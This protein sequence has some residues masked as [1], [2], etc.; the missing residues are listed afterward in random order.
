M[1]AELKHA[2]YFSGLGLRLDE[3]FAAEI[4][5]AGWNTADGRLVVESFEPT[6]LKQLRGRGIR[7][8]SVFLLETSGAPADLVAAQGSAAPSYASFLTSNGFARLSESVDGVSFDKSL[9]LRTDGDGQDA[10]ESS[11]APANLVA[12]AQAA[13]LTAYT[14]TLRPENLFLAPC[15][16]RGLDPAAFGDWLGEFSFI[17]RAGVD[18][19]FTDHPDLAVAA[20]GRFS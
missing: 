11:G 16:R 3:L 6:I 7:S 5:A 20:L 2:A 9:L 19:V 17:V 13:G 15:F 10:Q 1:V 8:H 14:W 4:T 12:A 18:G